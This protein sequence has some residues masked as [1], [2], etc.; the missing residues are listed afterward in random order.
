[1]TVLPL[2]HFWHLL[3]ILQAGMLN[4]WLFWFG[5]SELVLHSPG[6]P[7]GALS[8][9]MDSSACVLCVQAEKASQTQPKFTAYCLWNVALVP[10]SSEACRANR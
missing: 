4:R 1:M 8:S 5:L 3:D 2:L 9:K 10:V 7:A 6:L